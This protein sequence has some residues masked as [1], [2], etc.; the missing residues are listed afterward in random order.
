MSEVR[1]YYTTEQDKRTEIV[2]SLQNCI[3]TNGLFTVLSLDHIAGAE[4]NDFIYDFQMGNFFWTV[5]DWRDFTRRWLEYRQHTGKSTEF[6]TVT[7]A[8]LAT[9]MHRADGFR[10]RVDCYMPLAEKYLRG[11]SK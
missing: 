10:Y 7:I 8:L 3:A 5:D 6:N 4:Q 1:S 9:H 2:I 11:L